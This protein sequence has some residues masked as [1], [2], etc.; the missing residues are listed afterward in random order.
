MV[1]QLDNLESYPAFDP[2]EM[3]EKIKAM[4]QHLQDAWR[5]AQAS[6]LP[7][8]YRQVQRIVVLGMGGSAIG[9]DL[10]SGLMAY[11]GAVPVEVVRGYSLP[12][13]VSGLDTL[14]IASSK[15][16][17]TEETLSAF[18]QA[19]KRGARL[20]AIST[21]G[22]IA[23]I[24]EKAGIPA[25]RFAFVGQPR[26]AV[27]YSFVL[28]LGLACR[29]GFYPDVAE[30][31]EQ[32]ITHLTAMQADLVPEVPTAA[33]KA[34]QLAQALYGKIPAVF[35][36]GFLAPVARRWKGQFNENSKQWGL[37]EDMPELNH[38]LVVGLGKPQSA[39]D[40]VAVVFLRSVLDHPRVQ[41]RW[42]VTG[43]LVRRNNLALHEVYGEGATPLVQMFSLIHF[44]DFV[45]YYLA[46]LNDVDPTP[47]DNIAYLKGRLAE[48]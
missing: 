15:S 2:E 19:Q 35:G 1:F 30:A 32:T 20:M 6:P 43:E 13:Y 10:L 28:L 11:A 41:V 40:N 17:D 39:V 29:L 34:K 31:L 38:N 24:A 14:V 12:H 48:V 3:R 26:A 27:G 18:A 4:P 47:V 44:N 25:W 9:A 23:A 21:G 42:D 7:E 16:G 33:N 37:W 22:K 46:G 5:I 45:S 36:S 8:E